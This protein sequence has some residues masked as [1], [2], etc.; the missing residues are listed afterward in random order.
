MI[1]TE[2]R[3]CR[4]VLK[5]SVSLHNLEYRLQS[6]EIAHTFTFRMLQA[7]QAFRSLVR[8]SMGRERMQSAFPC[9]AIAPIRLKF[10][11]EITLWI[12]LEG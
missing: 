7:S 12:T 8:W 3:W 2:V 1:D 6:K 5:E 9:F 10:L 11:Q 4:T